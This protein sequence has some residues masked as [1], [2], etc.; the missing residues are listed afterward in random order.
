L[1]SADA[2]SAWIRRLADV[3]HLITP[4]S[5]V[6]SPADAEVAVVVC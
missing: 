5:C 6:A 4:Y 2:V 1:R 3:N